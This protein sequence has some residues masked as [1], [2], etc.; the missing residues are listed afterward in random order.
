MALHILY[1][2]KER[3]VGRHID[4]AVGLKMPIQ[5]HLSA[6]GQDP[7]GSGAPQPRCVGTTPLLTDA[8]PAVG[9]HHGQP[10]LDHIQM[11]KAS[12]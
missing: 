6:Q 4:L 8:R 12:V 5:P 11:P 3:C 1:A 2:R 10:G 9:R 7:D